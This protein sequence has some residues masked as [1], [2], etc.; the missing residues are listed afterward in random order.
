M[1]PSQDQSAKKKKQVKEPTDRELWAGVLYRMAEPVLSNMSEGKLQQNMLVELSPTW[2]GRNKNV[3]YMECFGR[4]M[5]GLAPWISLPDDDTAE[6]VQRKQLREWALKS[7][8]QAVDPESPDYLLWRKEGQTLVDA[9]YIAESFIRG[10]DAL[11]V[12]LDSVTKQR[13]ITE[14]TQLRRVDLLILT[15]CYSLPQW[16]LSC[17]RLVHR[18]ILIALLRLYVK[19]KNGMWEMAG[20][21]TVRI[22]FD[23][24][25]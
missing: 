25:N 19:W 4:L 11:W 21:R 23:L 3:T 5:A 13:Y 8:A 16:N 24:Y 17:V 7:Y 15:G 22:C 10:Y 9:A 18:V 2:D 1:T 20:I 6:G 12:P 14:F